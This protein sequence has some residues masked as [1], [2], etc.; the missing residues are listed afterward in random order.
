[1]VFPWS[2]CY[3]ITGV[4]IIPYHGPRVKKPGSVFV[5]FL[6]NHFFLLPSLLLVSFVILRASFNWF[7]VYVVCGIGACLWPPKKEKI[8]IQST[9]NQEKKTG[10][11]NDRRCLQQSL[12]IECKRRTTA[13]PCIPTRP[14][15]APQKKI[16]EREKKW[17]ST[18]YPKKNKK[19][20]EYLEEKEKTNLREITCPCG[21]SRQLLSV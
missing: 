14:L 13:C 2:S 12:W 20:S 21:C 19:I 6:A 9:W 15:Q 17:N 11:Q 8:Q 10:R 7:C 3:S 5:I 1:M 18:Q 16:V 4:L